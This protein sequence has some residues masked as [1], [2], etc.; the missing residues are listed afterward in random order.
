MFKHGNYNMKSLKLFNKVL[1]L[2][3]LAFRVTIGV[4]NYEMV[5]GKTKTS[6]L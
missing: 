5:F 4:V 1:Q 3:S 6:Y 2:A